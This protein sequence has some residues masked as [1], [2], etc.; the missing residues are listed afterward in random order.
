[1]FDIL[2]LVLL[3]HSLELFILPIHI[4]NL[5]TRYLFNN[6]SPKTELEF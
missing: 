3:C 1:M 4:D 2:I 5:Q 6:K